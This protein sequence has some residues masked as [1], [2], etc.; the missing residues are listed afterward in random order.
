MPKLALSAVFLLFLT[1]CA[2]KQEVARRGSSSVLTAE[3]MDQDLV[4]TAFDAVQRYRPQWLRPRSSP[5]MANP[6]P[7]SPTVYVDGVRMNAIT[8]LQLVQAEEV[9]QME[10]LA[11]T[12][13]TNRFGTDHTGGAILVTTR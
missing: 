10:Y 8:D 4:T 5:T 11:P 7:A 12:D 6:E 1:S 13:A 3:E 9:R 2:I